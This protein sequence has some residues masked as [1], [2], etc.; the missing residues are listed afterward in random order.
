MSP[1]CILGCLSCPGPFCIG[2]TGLDWCFLPSLGLEAVVL[3][4]GTAPRGLVRH[5]DPLPCSQPRALVLDSPLLKGQLP[6]GWEAVFQV[7]VLAGLPPGLC[8][9]GAGDKYLGT[10]RKS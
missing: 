9:A 5:A 6:A 1:R 10:D 4:D 8:P 2:W 7:C 3:G